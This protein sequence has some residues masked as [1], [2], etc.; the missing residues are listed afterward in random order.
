MKV[1]M[2]LREGNLVDHFEIE[3]GVIDMLTITDG[4]RM[5]ADDEDRKYI[6]RTTAMSLINDIKAS[7]ERSE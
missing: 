1:K 6:D 5:I 3:A 2:V 4:L 7:Y